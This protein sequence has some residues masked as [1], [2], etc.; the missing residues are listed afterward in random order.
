M[1]LETRRSFTRDISRIR[2]QSLL[3]RIERKIAEM[4]AAD[5]ITE[6]SS[7]EKLSSWSGSDY[8]IR[9]GNYRLGVTIEDEVAILV[10]FG[11]R[12]DF[13]QSFP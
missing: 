6:V 12:S 3:D 5:A 13:Y 7:V 1:K 8:R 11:H 4:E 9:I 2:N 10:R